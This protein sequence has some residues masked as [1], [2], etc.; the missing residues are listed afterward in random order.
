M[1]ILAIYQIKILGYF[2]DI[3]NISFVTYSM[4]DA[5]HIS[6]PNYA[7]ALSEIGFYC[8]EAILTFLLTRSRTVAVAK[9]FP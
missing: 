2:S 1:F 3:F 7:L 9:I 4:K 8:M 5:A 6:F